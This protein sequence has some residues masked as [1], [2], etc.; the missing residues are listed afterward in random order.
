MLSYCNSA[1]C[2]ASD[3]MKIKEWWMGEGG[4]VVCS[5]NLVGD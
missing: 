3:E 1:V 4:G 2:K 5:R